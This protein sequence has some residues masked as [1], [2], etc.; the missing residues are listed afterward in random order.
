MVRRKGGGREWSEAR[1]GE[2]V[3]RSKGGG[4]N[5]VKQERGEGEASREEGGTYWQLVG[6]ALVAI[7]EGG[8]WRRLVVAV[9]DGRRWRRL[10]V[11]IRFRSSW[12]LFVVVHRAP[13]SVV[14]S[15]L[16]R[17][18]TRFGVAG[19]ASDVRRGGGVLAVNDR[20]WSTL[21]VSR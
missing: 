19:L 13:P 17:V 21:V 20:A 11:V 10:V 7:R 12:T 14:R 8:R 4:G 15:C 18:V 2:G 9:R 6:S 3:V 5:G 16:S 1:E